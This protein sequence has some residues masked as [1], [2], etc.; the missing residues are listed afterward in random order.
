MAFCNPQ[1]PHSLIWANVSTCKNLLLRVIYHVKFNPFT[2]NQSQLHTIKQLFLRDRK[3]ERMSKYM[4]K[5]VIQSI[6]SAPNYKEKTKH[7]TYWLQVV[8]RVKEVSNK[9]H[10]VQFLTY[11]FHFCQL[12]Q[13]KSIAKKQATTSETP[14]LSRRQFAV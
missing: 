4:C 2:S 9:T 12:Q 14:L 1:A 8:K 3:K 7:N 10:Y 11:S 13:N 5:T 6:Q